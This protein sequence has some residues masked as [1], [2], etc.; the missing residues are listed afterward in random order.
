VIGE[1]WEGN[2]SNRG[3]RVVEEFGFAVRALMADS[4][5]VGRE[6]RG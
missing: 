3:E 6:M 4:V 2:G 5:G 1:A